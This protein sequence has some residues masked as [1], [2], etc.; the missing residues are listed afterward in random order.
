MSD[1]PP[2]PAN[3]AL[4]A[5]EVALTAVLADITRRH[6][7]PALLVSWGKDSMVLVHRLWAMGRDTLDRWLLLH[8]ADPQAPHKLRH[9]PGVI[10][11]Y[12][13]VVHNLMPAARLIHETEDGRLN[14]VARYRLE[15]DV[16]LAVPRDVDEP[17]PDPVPGQAVLC[18]RD[19]WVSGQPAAIHQ[20][21][22]DAYVIG[23]KDTDVDPVLGPI[24]LHSDQI[25]MGGGRP[26]HF[27]LRYWSDDD[28]WAY[29]ALHDLPTD[30][31]Y[32]HS[33]NLSINPD[34][35]QACGACLKRDAP[36]PVV[37]CPRHGLVP[38]VPWDLVPR[39]HTLRRAYFGPP[40][41]PVD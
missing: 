18:L 27:P 19:D 14:T 25:D 15:E 24:P 4:A 3:E 23:H 36:H 13:L 17:G 35:Q 10:R 38:P 21:G 29:T 40:P 1:L 33:S 34:W 12:G 41:Q 6:R 30:A 37:A 16:V 26:C 20:L 8:C 31:R 32:R 22:A 39:E 7:R 2:H 5:K 11:E 9:V 28:V